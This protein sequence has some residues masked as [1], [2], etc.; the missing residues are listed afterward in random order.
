MK[1]KKQLRPHQLEAKQAI[2]TALVAGGIPYADCCVSFGKSL[3]LADIAQDALK[4]GSR[5]L[6]ITPT[7]ELCKQNYDETFNCFDDAYKREIGIVC[8]GL[9]KKQVHRQVIIC[10]YQS[11]YSVRATA[12]KFD[13]VL[14]DECHIVSNNEQTQMRK[15]IKASQRINPKVK[16]VGVSGSPYRLGQ[17]TLENDNIEGKALFTECC[18]QSNIKEMIEKGYLAKIESV[19]S[20][21]Q[22]NMDGITQSGKSDF[23]QKLVEVK[24]EAIVENA[25]L[26]MQAQFTAHD[27][28]TA[29]IFTSS[30]KNAEHIK[31]C[32]IEQGSNADEIR[33]L[34][35][36]SSVSERKNA[37]KWLVEGGGNR[38]LI[39]IG[40]L[41]TGF[42][43]PALDC[44]VLFRATASLSLY[45][46][47]V[48]RVIRAH[49]KD[50]V[51]KIGLVIDYGTNI[52]RLGAIDA[53][54]PPKPKKSKDLAPMKPCTITLDRTLIDNDGFTH[55]RG[56]ECGMMNNLSAKKCVLC[57]AHFISES[58]DGKYSMLS[59]AQILKQKIDELTVTHRV[60]EVFFDMKTS[61]KTGVNMVTM[62]FIDEDINEIH[63]H[64]LCLDHEGVA[65]SIAKRFFIDMFKNPEDYYKL[66]SVGI[67]CENA[68]KLLSNKVKYE[69]FFKPITG[70]VV[71]P[72]KDNSKY[73]EIKNLVYF[74]GRGG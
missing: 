26:D 35:G 4:K 36:K 9:N 29:V 25:T 41:T 40:I 42:D 14:I 45:C 47:M 5:V 6:I 71:R 55:R 1:T 27:I 61:R 54:E 57:G 65:G 73:K 72:Q 18:Y 30:I 46:Q 74:V 17:G 67:T 22:V 32:W 31:Q 13:L 11:F 68:Y 15:I 59:K 49:N 39:N 37:L 51:D 2:R 20:S 64:Y 10:T 23:N 50:G 53:I 19:Q 8:S 38:Y 58:E 69:A 56:S 7:K 60:H 16:V 63:T 66:S 33:I 44:I 24:F 70:V 43:F 52:E 28:K 21:V 3:L 12:G 62:Q 48:G 34:T